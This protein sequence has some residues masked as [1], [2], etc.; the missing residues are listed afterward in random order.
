MAKVVSPCLSLSANGMINK[1]LVFQKRPSGHAV[2]WNKGHADPKSDGQL[3]VRAN[4]LEAKNAWGLLDD[5]Q[6]E[7]YNERA[8]EYTKTGRAMTGYNLY[9]KEYPDVTLAFSWTEQRPVGDSNKNWFNVGISSDGTKFIACE[10]GKRLWTYDGESWTEQ[11]PVGD[12]D[13]NWNNVG[14]SSDGTKFIACV[15]GGRLWTYDGESWTEQRPVGDSDENWNGTGI[16][17]DGTKF[18]AC[19]KIGRLWTYDG[20]SWTEQR[21]AGDSDEYWSDVA[22]SSDGTKFIVC[23]GWGRLYT[24]G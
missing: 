3:A 4:F 16:S 23:G 8:K 7:V 20:E 21:P 14:I 10:Q 13:K 24:Y 22:I 18:I 12:S 15:Y 6:K 11:R 1:N 2:F 5:D 17:S 19:I 9:V